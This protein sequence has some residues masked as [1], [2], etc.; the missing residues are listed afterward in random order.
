MRSGEIIMR[1]GLV[2]VRLRNL[3]VSVFLCICF[4]VVVGYYIGKSAD[5]PG[6]LCVCAHVEDGEMTQC[7]SSAYCRVGC[8]CEDEDDE[9]IDF[10]NM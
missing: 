8:A 6:I 4:G 10:T 7:R 1:E 2:A 9:D 3:I 5:I